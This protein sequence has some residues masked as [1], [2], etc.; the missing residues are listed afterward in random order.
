MNRSTLF[1]KTVAGLSIVVLAIAFILVI[2]PAKAEITV[3]AENEIQDGTVN[4]GMGT[5]VWNTPTLDLVQ[6]WYVSNPIT[7]GFM[8]VDLSAIPTNA[9]ITDVEICI[10]YHNGSGSSVS[11]QV[12]KR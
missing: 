5:S 7:N 9:I 3:L 2:S 6:R 4:K 8:I 12:I 11:L 1:Q 10:Y